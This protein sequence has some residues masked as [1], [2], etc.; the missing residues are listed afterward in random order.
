MASTKG[1]IRKITFGD[2]K[3]GLTYKVGQNMFSNSIRITAIIQD[4]AYFQEYG[5]VRY[6]VYVIR[7]GESVSQMWKS[8]IDLPIAIEYNMNPQEDYATY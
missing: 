7:S 2:L 5:K 8:F 1:I 6:D 4:D 3:D